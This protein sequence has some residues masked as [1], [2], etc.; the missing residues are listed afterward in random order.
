MTCTKSRPCAIYKP[1]I[2]WAYRMSVSIIHWSSCVRLFACRR[3]QN[4]GTLPCSVECSHC[5]HSVVEGV[6][7]TVASQAVWTGDCR[8]VYL[9]S[10]VLCACILRP[11]AGK[12][13]DIQR[14]VLVVLICIHLL[15]YWFD[16]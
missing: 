10:T 7:G 4:A 9:H 8:Q 12:K 11:A 3:T 14:P 15:L 16:I 5:L 13:S 6:C 1:L 2:A